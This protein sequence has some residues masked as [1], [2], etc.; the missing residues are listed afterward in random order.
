[1]KSDRIVV[2]VSGGLGN[3]LFQYAFAR[4]LS[5]IYGADVK[6]DGS[7]YRRDKKRNYVLDRYNIKINRLNR[8]DELLSDLRFKLNKKFG[9]GI[10]PAMESNTFEY[11][12][13][14]DVKSNYYVG[15]WQNVKYFDFYKSILMQELKCKKSEDKF[16]ENLI[17][18][19]QS[20]NAVACHV[21][22]GD[23][24][25]PDN[26][27]VYISVSMDYYNSAI[28]LMES[29]VE[30][31]IFY[32][33]SDDIDWCRNS[34]NNDNVVF[35]NS[36]GEMDDISEFELMRY[37]KHFIIANST[38]SWWAAYLSENTESIKVAP[39]KWFV[40]NEGAN[41]RLHAALLEGYITL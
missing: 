25:E 9:L 17:E 29:R 14:N 18:E 33:F 4:S 1:M 21:R 24:L 38:F 26:V 16:E 27:K 41:E 37:C 7:N 5:I 20:C 23:Y 8:F 40:T 34:F 11:L 30:D 13:I 3:Q 35:V 15:S 22:R 28:K 2:R 31:P 10:A 19:I 36:T 32:I 12:Q 39:S 6:L